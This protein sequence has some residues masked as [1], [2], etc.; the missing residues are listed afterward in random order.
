[1]KKI[2]Q[3]CRECMGELGKVVWPSRNEAIASVQVVIVSTIVAALILG[4]LDMLFT[5]AL[6]LIF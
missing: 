4:L 3:F 1:M 2:V 5:E 6:R